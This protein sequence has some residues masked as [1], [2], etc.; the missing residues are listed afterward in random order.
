MDKVNRIINQVFDQEGC[1]PLQYWLNM[2]LHIQHSL[3]KDN[4]SLQKMNK[5]CRILKTM[6]AAA[7]QNP[8]VTGDVK[9][10]LATEAKIRELDTIIQ[11]VLDIMT[12]GNE[13]Q[14]NFEEIIPLT[15]WR[16]DIEE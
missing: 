9:R 12:L 10:K 5:W 4:E 2:Q 1:S 7:A 15:D 6:L 8:G 16:S 13:V 14:L 11:A 3:F